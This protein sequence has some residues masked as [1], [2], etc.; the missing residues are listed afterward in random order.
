MEIVGYMSA[1]SRDCCGRRIVGYRVYVL[2]RI[3]GVS[4]R[5]PIDFFVSQESVEGM[6]CPISTLIGKNVIIKTDPYGRLCD[7]SMMM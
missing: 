3:V 5:K 6:G 4:G 2:D 1:T 7:F